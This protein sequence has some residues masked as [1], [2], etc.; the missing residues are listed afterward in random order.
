M[1]TVLFAAAVVAATTF[2]PATVRAQQTQQPSLLQS[3]QEAVIRP[4]LVLAD[5]RAVSSFLGGVEIRGNEVDAYLDVKHALSTAVD[6]ATKAGKKDD[7]MI[8][9]DMRLDVA[10]NF[11]VLMQRATLKA[12]EAEKFKQIIGAVQEAAK[13][14]QNRK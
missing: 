1:R 9:V 10:Q 2:I 8:V 4:K 3:Q 6:A 13:E 11:Y 14:V 12:A 7:D 5:V